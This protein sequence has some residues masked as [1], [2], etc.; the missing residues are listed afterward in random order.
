M[1]FPP[2]TRTSPMSLSRERRSDIIWSLAAL[3]IVVIGV[4]GF[5]AL[6]ALK[7]PVAAIDIE[8]VVTP[9]ESVALVPHASPVPVRGEGFVRPYRELALAAE[10]SGRV[11]ELHPALLSRGTVRAG[12]TL[13]RLDDRSARAALA[14]TE[15]DIASTRARLELNGTQ[16]ARSETLRRRGVISQDELDQRAAQEAEL[17]AALASLRSARRSAEIT[18]E[19]T[20]V[21]A[22]FDARVLSR[23]VEL[24]SVVS[25]GQ[26]LAT[27]F[28]P[29]EIE[30]TVPLT[31]RAASLIPDLFDGG[32]APATVVTSFA[33][34]EF[35]RDARVSRVAPALG[36]GTRMLDVTVAVEVGSARVPGEAG[37]GRADERRG[38]RAVESGENGRSPDGVPPAGLP[39]ALI[40]SYAHVVIEGEVL[41][42][43]YALPSTAVRTG[44]LSGTSETVWLVVG[45]RLTVHQAETV[46]V[47][48]ATSYVRLLELP[49]DAALVI[50]IVDA[51]VDGMPVR[52][53]RAD[54]VSSDDDGAGDADGAEPSRAAAMA[55]SE[56]VE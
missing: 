20:T 7:E 44:T 48:G 33:G 25:P 38:E 1:P 9:V 16:L 52:E 53:T 22:P 28:T 24:G 39:P 10:M 30:V 4:L 34:R 21:T 45:E 50:G 12:E 8:R 2:D 35:V 40:G 37:G 47:D 3:G 41:D 19:N 36:S 6:G 42:E 54:G 5:L 32:E 14:R 11:I 43:L 27:L 17:S 31:E 15:S 26:T 56:R 29:D 23:E 46:H 13:V 51:P 18:L 49:P 55:R